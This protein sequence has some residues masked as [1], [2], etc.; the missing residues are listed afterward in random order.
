MRN[1]KI[2]AV[3]APKISTVD[4]ASC[5]LSGAR[6]ARCWAGETPALPNSAGSNEIWS[7]NSIDAGG[8]LVKRKSADHVILQLISP[9]GFF[10]QSR[11]RIGAVQ[12][13]GTPVLAL[14]GDLAKIFRNVI[15]RKKRFILSIWSFVVSDPRPTLA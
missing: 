4:P 14:I 10:K 8:P 12:N 2:C 7:S 11:L 6:P 13:C 15:G 1:F 5:R 3:L 9:H